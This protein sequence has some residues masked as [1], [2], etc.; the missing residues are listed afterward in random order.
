MKICRF[1]WRQRWFSRVGLLLVVMHVFAWLVLQTSLAQAAPIDQSS[2]V[3][4]SEYRRT[5]YLAMHAY[6][7]SVTNF[8]PADKITADQIFEEYFSNDFASHRYAMG[9][10]G[11]YAKTAIS[12]ASFYMYDTTGPAYAGQQPTNPN[13]AGWNY[14]PE[15]KFVAMLDAAVK[16]NPPRP[17]VIHFNGTR[18]MNPEDTTPC[19]RSPANKSLW[20]AFATNPQLNQLQVDQFEQPFIGLRGAGAC[21]VGECFLSIARG[22]ELNNPYLISCTS[23]DK[24]VMRE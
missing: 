23:Q 18:W 12:F 22:G 17:I 7:T 14:Q 2:F 16:A 11:V 4:D 19:D 20:C 6:P 13:E 3:P 5:F 21:K 15:P 24:P 9:T 8:D 1:F 10:G